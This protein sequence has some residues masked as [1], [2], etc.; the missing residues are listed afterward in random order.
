MQFHSLHRGFQMSC[1]VLAVYMTPWAAA[2]A[3]QPPPIIEWQVRGLLDVRAIVTDDA[4]SW[5]NRGPGKFRYGGDL[6][7]SRQV[8]LRGEGAVVVQARLPGDLTVVNHIAANSQQHDAIDVIESFISY[9]PAQT[10]TFAFRAKAGAFIP[11]LSLENTGLGWTSPYTI[12]SSAINT[13]I[14]E[15]LRSVGAEGSVVAVSDVGEFSAGAAVFGYNDPVGSLLSWRGWA[16]HDREAGLFDRLALPR[17]PGFLPGG[18]AA[19]QSNAVRPIA[20][21]DDRVGYYVNAGWVGANDLKIRVMYYNNL[22]NSLKFD[23]KQYGWRTQFLAAGA[24]WPLNDSFEVIAQAVTGRTRMAIL[25]T[26]TVVDNDFN[27][28]FVLLSHAFGKHRFSTRAEYFDVNDR[29][30]TR[31]D[32]NGERG[33]AFT[34]AYVFRPNDS[35]RLTLEVA[36]VRSVRAARVGLGLPARATET[37]VQVSYRYFFSAH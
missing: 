33:R 24:S 27:S 22:A 20:E 18:S 19:G 2:M 21:L 26:F 4:V 7:N 34:A 9:K 13:W 25:P 3:Q 31:D 14:G 16:I 5:V 15:E 35:Q 6:S 37:Q 12:S 10:S 23:G 36:N 32:L 28:A 1:A 29:D 11:S 8:L 30:L 17:L